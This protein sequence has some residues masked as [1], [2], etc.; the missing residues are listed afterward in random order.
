MPRHR[1]RRA[2]KTNKKVKRGGAEELSME[3]LESI[4]DSFISFAKLFNF[5]VNE[6]NYANF[7]VALKDFVQ[8][9][10]M[11]NRL[12]ETSDQDLQELPSATFFY[13]ENK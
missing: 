13:G 10:E 7:L 1:T 12:R 6:G 9:E 5:E 2:K 11:V 8:D 3:Q 4:K